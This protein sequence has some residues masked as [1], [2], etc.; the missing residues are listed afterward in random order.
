MGIT[1]SPPPPLDQ[2]DN[3]VSAPCCG[4]GTC[5]SCRGW[6]EDHPDDDKCVGCYKESPGAPPCNLR[7]TACMAT[8]GLGC[9]ACWSPKALPAG[10]RAPFPSFLAPE[11]PVSTWVPTAP[12]MV[13]EVAPALAVPVSKF[14]APKNETSPNDFCRTDVPQCASCCTGSCTGC[15][16]YCEGTK[17]GDCIHCWTAAEGSPICNMRGTQCL[18]DDG[19]SCELCWKPGPPPSPSP[20]PTPPTPTP[21]PTPGPEDCPGGTFAACI[22]LCPSDPT[23]DFQACLGECQRRCDDPWKVV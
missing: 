7:G 4:E 23:E 16:G 13:P 3:P 12:V 14:M 20:A 22:S 1:N 5:H 21:S 18:A 9:E 10:F 2:C 6:C 15:R 11:E 17:D 8:D 19:L